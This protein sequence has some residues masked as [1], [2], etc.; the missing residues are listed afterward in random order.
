[1]VK[2]KRF[3]NERKQKELIARSTLPELYIDLDGVMANFDK[4]AFSILGF[5]PRNA[6][7]LTKSDWVDI[8]E[9]VP[10][11]WE[12]LE[13]LPDHKFLW[14]FAKKYR[15]HILSARPVLWPGDEPERGKRKWIKKHLGK[16][17]GGIHIVKRKNK[18]QFATKHN[19]PNVL[20]DDHKKNIQEWEDTGGI[21][22]LHI[23]A[24]N[25]ISKLKEL[26]F[27]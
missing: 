1:M 11:F 25:S 8:K 24:K 4:K 21:G 17:S 15:P 12:D 22:I 18:Q 14:N 7:P 20:I 23:S 16:V 13:P 2:F 10:T 6:K 3:L 26:G 27:K 9:K 19:Q 5:N